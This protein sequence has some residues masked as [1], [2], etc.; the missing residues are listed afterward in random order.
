MFGTTGN[1]WWTMR[2]QVLYESEQLP[3]WFT[4]RAVPG[5]SWRF[6]SIR[7]IRF[8]IQNTETN[9]TWVQSVTGQKSELVYF[10]VTGVI[11]KWKTCSTEL[12]PK[13]LMLQRFIHNWP[14]SY[15][16]EISSQNQSQN[17]VISIDYFTQP[18]HDQ[19]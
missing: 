16:W 9:W 13:T 2:I 4:C 19:H 8:Y 3:W 1:R 18:V 11:F 7:P 17:E 10:P 14:V 5:A 12:P 6:H 15:W